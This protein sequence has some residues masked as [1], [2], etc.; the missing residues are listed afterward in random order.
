MVLFLL[1][2]MLFGWLD[3][4][5]AEIEK[6]ERVIIT[7][8]RYETPLRQ[9]TQSYTLIGEGEIS[10]RRQDRVLE[11]LRDVPSVNI[12]RSGTV[13]GNTTAFLRGANSAQTLVLIDGIE[14][15]LPT[16][17]SFDFGNLPTDN[18]DRIEIIRG[19][20]STLY[21]SEAMGGVINIITERGKGKPHFVIEGEG[22]SNETGRGFAQALGSQGIFDYS[23]AGSYLTTEGEFVNDAYENAN[24]SGN[25]G[26]EP[27][28]NLRVELI[29]RLIRARK[30][31]QDFGQTDPDPNRLNRS[32][33]EL[34]GLKANHWIC[35]WWE[36]NLILSLFHDRLKDKDPLDSAE[37]GV[38]L[39]TEIDN[40]I[41]TI[42]WESHFYWGDL[43]T[44][45]FGLEYE[46]SQGENDTTGDPFNGDFNFEKDLDNKAAFIQDQFNVNDW[47]FIVPGVR[48][49]DQSV[50][51]TE[52][53][54]KISGAIW[55]L[56]HTKLKA[57]WG[58]GFRA[59]SV[60]E[61]VFPAFGNPNLDAEESQSWEVGLEQTF[62][63]E[64]AGIDLS[65]FQNDFD[66]LIAFEVISV[67]P[68]IGQANNIA[69]AK[70]E[71]VE[72]SAFVSPWT[73]LTLRGSYTY[74]DAEDEITGEPLP[75]RP[76]DSG[77]LLAN[78]KWGRFKLVTNAIFVGP[79]FDFDQELAG[80]IKIDMAASYQVNE[81]WM[82]YV[83]AEN[84]LD[85]DYEEAS[86]FPANGFLIFVGVRV[87]V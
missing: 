42:Q 76:Q 52:V 26:V 53:S 56:T 41:R 51:G 14:V 80:F 44:I 37:V 60:N 47:I 77:A 86:G 31:I 84:L 19:P 36:Q 33:T 50:F 64:K 55:I 58:E 72:L 5:S 2:W 62:W 73:F 39:F 30:E 3:A 16:V 28:E 32:R 49:D 24:F 63:D 22:G 7:A 12:V 65:Y 66:N 20:Q 54:P 75:R 17:G 35:D 43:Q 45:T 15:N 23:L 83:R 9:I 79:R 85:D 68:F 81:H 40:E 18:V 48:I 6:K 82:P 78:I 13:G 21:G 38:P 74:L 70:T 34:V 87:D 59:P 67:T 61:L 4:D 8:T 57:S 29:T 1:G 71:G 25:F 27:W 11:V 10:D 46:A 69:E